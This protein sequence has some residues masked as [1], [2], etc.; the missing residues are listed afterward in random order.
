MSA[1]AARAEPATVHAY[2]TQ[3][4]ARP[5]ARIAYGPG[6][7]QVVE[8]FLPRGRP[9][10]HPVIVLLHGGCYRA[11]YEGLR[12]TSAI[13]ADLAARG[14]AVWNIDYRKLGEPGAA[15]P[16]P[17]LDVAQAVDRIRTEA[18]VYRLL[19]ERLPDTTIIS[20][21][22][23]STLKVFHHRHLTLHTEGEN[24]RIG[25]A[26]PEPQPELKP[27]PAS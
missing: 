4:Q 5:T 23:R 3:P 24:R 15:Y 25:E 19:H 18:K 27:Q 22:H 6:P 14:Y 17:F 11:D 20:I 9:G 21:G 2:M 7:S 13:A 12:Q 10:P 1:C 26:T 8:L 16:G